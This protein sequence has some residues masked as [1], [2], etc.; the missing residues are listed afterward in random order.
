MRHLLCICWII[1]LGVAS[2][3]PVN[4]AEDDKKQTFQ[5]QLGNVF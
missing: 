2:V 4:A 1:I 3:A 5:F